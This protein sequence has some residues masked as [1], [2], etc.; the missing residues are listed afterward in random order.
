MSLA[1]FDLDN[2]LIAGD[3]DHLWGQFLIEHKK[4][5]SGEFKRMNDQFYE[6]YKNSCLDINA[7]LQFALKPLSKFSLDALNELHS[8]FMHEKIEPIMLKKSS[9]LI[10]KHRDQGDTLLII[11]AT[12]RFVTQPIAQKLK[13]DN[14]L[15]S[16]GEIINN[17]YTGQPT[18]TPCYQ[19][20]KVIRLAQWMKKTGHT[21]KNSY[22]YSDSINDVPLLSKVDNPVAVDPD[23]SLSEWALKHNAPILSLR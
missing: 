19:E 21:L 23:P 14:L 9:E 5:D 18:G 15:A 20:G 10:K 3:S 1:I 4:V 13:I 7:Y 22:F 11:T 6:D 8:L 17:M 12:N 2:T 16:E